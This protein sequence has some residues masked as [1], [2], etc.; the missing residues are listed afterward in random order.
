MKLTVLGCGDAF[1]SEGRFNTSF[2]LSDTGK[3]ILIDCGA[4][5]LIRLKQVGVSPLDIE[6]IVITHFHGD[7]YG[8]LP[9]FVISNYVE[10]KRSEPFTIIGPVGIEKR[11]MELQE[12][13]YPGSSQMI[14]SMGVVFREFEDGLVTEEGDLSVYARMVVHSPDSNPHGVKVTWRNKV[15][16]FS[17]D[18][19]W[20]ESLIDL[21]S[22]SDV[23][24]IECNNYHKDSPGHLSYQTILEKRDFFK[25]KK[26][27]MTHMGSE[28]INM[29]DLEID[30][31]YDGMSLSI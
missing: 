13:M 2:L 19:E 6:T 29:P 28:V 12:A 26:L 10:L 30:K 8:G 9:F 20:A 24:I 31:L 18:T 27:L 14:D 11:V 21:A 7:H 25:T 22:D 17:G 1:A 3:N 15:V 5:S 23:F 4:S 16:A